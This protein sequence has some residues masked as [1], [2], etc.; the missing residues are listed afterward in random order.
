VRSDWATQIEKVTWLFVGRSGA[1]AIE[2]ASQQ[3]LFAGH[4]GV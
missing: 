1:D 2:N 3:S 4:A